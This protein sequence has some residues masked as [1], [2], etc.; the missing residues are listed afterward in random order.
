MGSDREAG[1]DVAI[2]AVEVRKIYGMKDARVEALR[3]I[4]AEVA[5]GERVGLLGKSGSGKSTFLNLL[6]GLDRPSSGG[7]H[8]GGSDLHALSKREMARFRSTTV[9]IIFQ[10]FNL[11]ASRT[12]VEN[13]ELPM[14]FAGESPRRRRAAALAALEAVGLG[15]RLDHRPHQMSGGENQR[16]AVA[17]AL[18]NRPRVILADEPTGNLDSQT[19]RQVMA[20]ILDYVREHDATLVLVTHDEELAA[21]CTDR[22]VRLVD[23]RIAAE[24]IV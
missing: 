8:V 2:R 6:G 23:G 21:A 3:G 7:L 9:G 10:S 5:H 4:S 20:L 18:V 16:V 24:G 12:A 22:I 15:G 14:V 13:V 11:I 19:A 1:D 17:R